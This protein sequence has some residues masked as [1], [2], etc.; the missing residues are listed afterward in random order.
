MKYTLYI[1]HFHPFND[2]HKAK[3]Q[4]LLDEGKNVLIA[5]WHSSDPTNS[6]TCIESMDMIHRFFHP[7][8][9]DRVRI[10]VLGYEVEEIVQE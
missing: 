7:K 1:N 4:H 8:Y 2:D 5:I 10:T 9:R 6:S 3:V